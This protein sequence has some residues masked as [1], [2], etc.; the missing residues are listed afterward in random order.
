MAG[1][2]RRVDTGAVNAT[3]MTTSGSNGDPPFVTAS[4]E[5]IRYAEELRRKI[6]QRYLTPTRRSDESRRNVATGATRA[7]R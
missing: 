4:A 2:A 1:A 6:E 5:E 7:R 3:N